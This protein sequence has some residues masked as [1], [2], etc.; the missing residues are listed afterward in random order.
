MI[1]ASGVL[2][3]APT[4]MQFVPSGN[5]C[6]GVTGNYSFW[7]HYWEGDTLRINGNVGTVSRLQA[8]GGFNLGLHDRINLIVML[9]YVR[10]QASQGTLNGQ[11][12]F[13]D[14]SL[15]VKAN[16]AQLA[17]GRSSLLIGGNVGCAL[18]VSDYL[19]DFM[20]LSI[21]GGTVNLSYRQM[22]KF[23]LA[24]GFYADAKANYTWRSNIKNVHRGG[25]YYDHGNAYYTDEVYVPNTLDYAGAIGYQSNRL[26]A[27]IGLTVFNTLGGS[28]IR[29]WDVPFV[30]VNSDFTTGYGRIDYYFAKPRGLNFSLVGGQTLSGRN[31]GKS[32]YVALSLNYLFALWAQPKPVQ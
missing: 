12:G 10:T 17:L 29:T 14:L 11:H 20:P 32:T 26:L 4:D 25:F 15:N 21:G 5:I 30:T 2:A 27:E 22:L 28:D 9:P 3:Q 23:K 6:V 13:S 7:D 31:A 1:T 8:M 16:Y 18:P 19:V 24:T